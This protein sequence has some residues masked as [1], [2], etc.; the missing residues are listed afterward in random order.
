MQTSFGNRIR[1]LR[2]EKFPGQSLRK[3]GEYLSEKYEFR[4]YFYTQLN[5]VEMGVILPSSELLGRLLTAYNVSREEREEVYAAYA[6]QS[7]EESFRMMA[8]DIGVRENAVKNAAD[9][10]YRKVRKSK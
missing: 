3:V 6:S 9:L 1:K 5:K 7:A 8:E 10:L 2:E 4:D